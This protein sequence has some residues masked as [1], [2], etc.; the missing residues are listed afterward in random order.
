MTPRDRYD[1]ELPAEPF[2]RW[3]RD[4]EGEFESRDVMSE[5]LGMADKTLREQ[6]AGGRKFVHVD[7]VD[8]ALLA[9]GRTRLDDL[10][11]LEDAA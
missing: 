1:L 3:L 10:Y 8:R 6:L 11:P 5:A 9:D 7:V 4:R 2:Q